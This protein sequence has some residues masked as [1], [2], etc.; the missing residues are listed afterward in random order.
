MQSQLPYTEL[1]A[2]ISH[3]GERQ[4]RSR[5]VAKRLDDLMPLRLKQIQEEYRHRHAPGKALRL[6]LLSLMLHKAIFSMVLLCFCAATRQWHRAVAAM[7]PCSPV[8]S[9]CLW[10]WVLSLGVN[11]GSVLCIVVWP[12]PSSNCARLF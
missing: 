9:V 5:Q 3:C 11:R 12:T 4:A 10:G 1:S 2:F 8:H 7:A 6:A